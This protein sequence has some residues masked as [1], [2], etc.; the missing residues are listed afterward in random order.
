M[1]KI[2]INM[3]DAGEYA[4]FNAAFTKFFE[5]VRKTMEAGTSF[6]VLETANFIVFCKDSKPTGVMGFYDAR[7]FAYETGLLAGEGVL[8]K[9]APEPTLEKVEQ[10]FE[11]FAQK[12]S[13]LELRAC[14]AMVS[15]VF[16]QLRAST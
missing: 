1:F 7:D 9:N 13:I 4:S 12:R 11:K 14:L 6:Q 2:L 16:D 10:G 3:E 8:Q 15:E 5:E